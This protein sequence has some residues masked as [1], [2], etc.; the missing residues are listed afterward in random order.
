MKSYVIYGNF[1][2]GYEPVDYFETKEEARENLREYRETG[3]G[4]YVCQVS[5]VSDPMNNAVYRYC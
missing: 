2:D 1:G 4:S 5:F 3:V